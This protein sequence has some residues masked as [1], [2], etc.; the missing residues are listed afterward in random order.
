MAGNKIYRLR[1]PAERTHLVAPVTVVTARRVSHLQ[2]P[3]MQ[4]KIRLEWLAHVVVFFGLLLRELL[5]DS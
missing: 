4:K 2:Q 1:S 5:R 3:E